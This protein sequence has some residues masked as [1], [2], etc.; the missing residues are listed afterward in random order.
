MAQL[1]RPLVMGVLNVTPDSF[2]DGGLFLDADAAVAHG[3]GM[4][5]EGADVIDVGGASTRPGAVAPSP[6]EEMARVVPVISALVATGRARV[7]IDTMTPEVARAAVEAGADLINDVSALLWP[8]A[9]EASVGWV[10]MHMQGDPRTMQLEPHYG[11]V[12][13]EIREF[14][15]DRATAASEAGIAEVWIDP[16][17]GFGKTVRHNLTL[18]R[19]LDKFCRGKYPV[20]IGI[21][22]KSFLGKLTPNPDGSTPDAADRMEASIAGAVWAA[23]KGVGMVRVHDVRA[24]VAA[25]RIVCDVVAGA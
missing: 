24:T 23:K 25:V 10:C 6:D 9:A 8:V 20:L 19:N 12:V 7:S 15:D 21:S 4:I 5:D 18:L 17:I 2:S 11:D 1:L 13:A 3:L 16:G 14:L 22:R